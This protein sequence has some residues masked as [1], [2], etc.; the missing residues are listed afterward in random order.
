MI[1]DKGKVGI[2]EWGKTVTLKRDKME[3]SVIV[4]RKTIFYDRVGRNGSAVRG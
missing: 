1:K 2:E 3:M 4:F